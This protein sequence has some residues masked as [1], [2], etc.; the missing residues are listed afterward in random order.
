LQKGAEVLVEGRLKIE[1]YETRDGQKRRDPVI[2]ADRVSFGR[3]PSGS[4]GGGGNYGGGGGSYRRDENRQAPPRES[5]DEAPDYDQAPG[6]S[7][8]GN[9]EDDL[10]F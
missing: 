8:S 10:P 9:T 4:G 5:Y 2:T 7:G 3:K 1:E 6:P